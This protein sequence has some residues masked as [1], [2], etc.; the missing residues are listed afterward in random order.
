MTDLIPI[1]VTTKIFEIIRPTSVVLTLNPPPTLHYRIFR[2]VEPRD[3]I[4]CCE[5]YQIQ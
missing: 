3:N 4:I 5:I 1:I 2:L